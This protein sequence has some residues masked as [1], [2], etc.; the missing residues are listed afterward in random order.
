M[1]VGGWGGRD[2][3]E[4]TLHVGLCVYMSG[5]TC[6]TMP[7]SEGHSARGSAAG[8]VKAKRERPDGA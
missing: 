8:N 4:N 1:A 2:V 7:D 3:D 6:K 5:A